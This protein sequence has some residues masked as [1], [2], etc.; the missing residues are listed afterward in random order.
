VRVWHIKQQKINKAPPHFLHLK[1]D[2]KF[3]QSQMSTVLPTSFFFQ[4][5]TNEGVLEEWRYR[6]TH[7]FISVLDRGEWSAPRPGRLTLREK[8]P[9]T[10]WIGVWVGSR[11]VLDALVKRK[12]PSPRWELNP[13]TPIIQPVAELSRLWKLI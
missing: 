4:L 6:F 7:S 5:S 10:H 8:V 3:R 9:G 13:R 11:A 12:I 1:L 2:V